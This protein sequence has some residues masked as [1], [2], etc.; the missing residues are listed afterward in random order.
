MAGRRKSV[1]DVRELIRMLRAGQGDRRIAGD[2]GLSRNTVA[3]YRRWASREGLLEAPELPMAVELEQMLAGFLQGPTVVQES[4]V[5]TF[6]EFVLEKTAAGVEMKSIWQMLRERGFEGSYSAVRRFLARHVPRTPEAF[7]RVETQAGEEAQVDFGYAGQFL[8]PALGRP[9]K[10]WVFVMTLSY[11]RHQYVR[12]VFDQ[13]VE[14]WIDLHV[15]AFEWF[16]GA[17]GRIVIDNLKAGIVRAVLHD[18]EVQRSYRELAE[19]YGFLIAPCRPG[20]PRHKGKVESGVRYVNRSALAGREFRDVEEAN[21]HLERWAM[22]IA[23]TR[24]H[25]TTHEAPLAR[26]E[27]ERSHLKPLPMQRYEVVVWKQAMVHP[28]C[29][30]V[31]DYAY[32]SAPHRLIGQSLWIRATSS[33]VEL[34]CHHERIA[35]HPRAT[36]KGEWSTLPDH[37]PPTKLQGLLVHPQLIRARARTIG[38][39]TEEVIE[40]LLGDRPLDRL[41]TAQAILR[42][43]EREGAERLEAAC[44]RSIAYD[45]IR[46]ATIKG[47]L[48]N[49]LDLEPLPATDLRP[50]PLPKTAIFA[51]TVPEI[52]LPRLN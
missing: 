27:R 8:D 28:D 23:G 39:N 22:E 10:S 52:V 2:M 15:R 3:K 16:G 47:I 48:K 19:H 29:H 34:Y 40:R 17:P 25:G 50:G 4:T 44:R 14:T 9:R 12:I 13:R 21:R 24:D 26:F 20:T 18:P 42:L 30:I 1:F 5:E 11:S 36:R 32:Y 31:F 49:G 33:R 38:P 43:G 41:R 51:R 46:Y 7:V 45:E 35:T 37:L 6:R